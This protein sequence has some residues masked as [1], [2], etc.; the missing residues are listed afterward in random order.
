MPRPGDATF[1]AGLYR[2]SLTFWVTLALGVV[3]VFIGLRRSK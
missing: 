3:F 2:T 1:E